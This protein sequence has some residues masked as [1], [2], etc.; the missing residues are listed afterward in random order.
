MEHL[1]VIVYRK[2]ELVVGLLMKATAVFL[3]TD[4]HSILKHM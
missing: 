3:V 1:D 4:I 2:K